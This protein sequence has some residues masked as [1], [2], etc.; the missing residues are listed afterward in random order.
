MIPETKDIPPNQ[1]DTVPGTYWLAREITTFKVARL[2]NK[3]Q[4]MI[5]FTYINLNTE[6]IKPKRM[7]SVGWPSGRKGLGL[8]RGPLPQSPASAQSQGNSPISP[9]AGLSG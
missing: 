2:E 3:I 6:K 8:V 7:V 4:L 1:E 9:T 5:I